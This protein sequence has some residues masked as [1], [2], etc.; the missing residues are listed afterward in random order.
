M[1]GLSRDYRPTGKDSLKMMIKL[2]HFV[3]KS[4]VFP[5]GF[6]TV[7]EFTKAQVRQPEMG[8]NGLTE[9]A[10]PLMMKRLAFGVPRPADVRADSAAS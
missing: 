10:N 4:S 1:L 6:S 5:V 9:P 7:L 3:Y 2:L 8:C